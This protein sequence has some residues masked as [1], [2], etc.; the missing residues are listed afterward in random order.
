M[1]DNVVKGRFARTEESFGPIDEEIDALMKRHGVTAYV[2]VAE[3][4]KQL[5][6][7]ASFHGITPEDDQRAQFMLSA[8]CSS[9]AE[10]LRDLALGLYD[11]EDES[12]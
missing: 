8:V 9:K 4:G 7:S 3:C 12:Q 5:Y 11:D 1:T 2:F 6:S 10:Q